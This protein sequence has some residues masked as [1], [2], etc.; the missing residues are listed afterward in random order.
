MRTENGYQFAHVEWASKGGAVKK[1]AAKNGKMSTRAR[2]WCANEIA[3]EA[4]RVDG[5]CGH[6]DNPQAP[7]LLY[8]QMPR[9]AVLAGEKWAAGKT[10]SYEKTLKD[11][12]KKTITRNYREDAPIMSCGVISLPRKREADWDKFKADSVG[13]L[14]KKYGQRLLSVVEHLDEAHPHLHF[15]AVPLAGEDFGA[16]HEGYAA[17]QHARVGDNKVKSAYID[18]M[19]GWQ[20]EFYQHVGQRFNL[21]RIGPAR[22]RVS[23]DKALIE[24]D[25]LKAKNAIKHAEK[26][27]HIMIEN[28]QFE[29]ATVK[30]EREIINTKKAEI[31]L[32]AEHINQGSKALEQQRLVVEQAA[33]EA[34]Q[35]RIEAEKKWHRILTSARTLTERKAKFKKAR[36]DLK[37]EQMRWSEPGAKISA[38]I[39]N[40]TG[41]DKKIE[42]VTRDANIKIKKE[43]QRVQATADAEIMAVKKTADAASAEAQK[44]KKQLAS[45]MR[46]VPIANALRAL[47]YEYDVDAQAYVTELG[48]ARENGGS[49]TVEHWTQRQPRNAIDMVKGLR[50]I[51]AN[52]AVDLIADACGD[53][54]PPQPI[55]ANDKTNWQ[56]VRR[57]LIKERG[58]SETLVDRMEWR[59]FLYADNTPNAV[60]LLGDDHA[61]GAELRGTI[62]GLNNTFKGTRGEKACFHLPP[63]RGGSGPK[64]AIVAES[65]IEAVSLQCLYPDAYCI[66][67]GGSNYKKTLVEM[68]KMRQKGYKIITAMNNDGPGR[69]HAAALKSC[70]D[71]DIVP[72][73]V[74]DWNNVLRDKITPPVLPF[75]APTPTPEPKSEPITAP[76]PSS[77]ARDVLREFPEIEKALNTPELR[78]YLF[79]GLEQ[80]LEDQP[81]Q[82]AK[83]ERLGQTEYLR[84]VLLHMDTEKLRALVSFG[85][86]RQRE[87]NASSSWAGGPS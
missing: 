52:D 47:D 70:A 56:Y 20:D 54:P 16:V 76:A 69:Q 17:R 87:Y 60:F 38:L 80:V 28:A 44:A 8:G 15:Y 78:G 48:Y 53:N 18:A 25:K 82:S 55:P 23:R 65:A 33:H 9:A 13:W 85:Y 67:M 3:D 27:A 57:Y 26:T 59:G 84:A 45:V 21:D 50:G 81:E 29:R 6:V 64:I 10:S 73:G 58:L 51:E 61:R 68:E 14:Q 62:G 49:W 32:L 34:D 46:Q 43:T 5:A 37:N 12:S 36:L 11:G 86:E 31:K 74:V 1:S 66:G 2:G 30:A 42:A 40:V 35:N 77:S 24:G 75:T 39:Y 4:E 22:Q 7:R 83:F 41:A 79:S 19:K 63:P 71:Y 72:P